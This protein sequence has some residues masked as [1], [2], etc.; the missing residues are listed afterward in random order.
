MTNPNAA[1]LAQSRRCLRAMLLAAALAGLNL[2]LA[3]AAAAGPVEIRAEPVRVVADTLSGLRQLGA[4]ELSS[5]AGRFGGFSGMVVEGGRLTAVSDRGLLLSAQFAE[6]AGALT[7]SDA[8]LRRLIETD[9]SRL[10]GEGGDAEALTRLDSQLFVAFE[11]DHRIAPLGRDGTLGP[12]VTQRAFESLPSNG[13]IE[14]LAGAGRVLLA[15]PETPQDDKTAA[16]ALSPD[17]ELLG[18]GR[19]ATPAPHVV[20]D[21][22]VGP[23]GRLYVVLRDFSILRGVSIR[24]RRHALAG[25]PPLPVEGPGETLAAFAHSSGIDNM[26]AIALWRDAQGRL[27]LWLMSDDNFNPLQRTLLLDFEVTP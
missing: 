18:T 16:L 8:T 10:R 14:G 22:A 4:W 9:G 7:F 20:T 23:D 5:E 19:L 24:V 12:S 25:S 6:T 3:P 27:R 13:G 15:F 1:R 2:P 26:E 21:A 17:G 11:R